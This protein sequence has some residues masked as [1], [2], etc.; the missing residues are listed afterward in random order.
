MDERCVK[1][2]QL[3][4]I[5]LECARVVSDHLLGVKARVDLM[6]EIPNHFRVSV[7]GHLW[8]DKHP[9]KVVRYPASW[10]DHFKFSKFPEWAKRRWPPKFTYEKFSFNTLY[11]DFKPS[12]PDE[13]S[14]FIHTCEHYTLSERLK[15]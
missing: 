6:H 8:G 12:L 15:P 3:E 9:D 14:S 10:W 5:K 7:K 13:K 11:P 4:K 2:V 1:T